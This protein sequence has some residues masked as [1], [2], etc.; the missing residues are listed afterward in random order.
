MNQRLK[1]LFAVVCLLAT[2]VVTIATSKNNS[3]ERVSNVQVTPESLVRKSYY[4]ASNCPQAIYQDWI[5]VANERIEYPSNRNF[6]SFGLPAQ[7]LNLTH[8]NQ[9]SMMINGRQRSCIRSEIRDQT[10]LPLIVYTCEESGTLLCQVSFEL[11]Q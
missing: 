2:S 7:T 4:V 11:D 1:S 9:I 8:T 5:T 3:G 6:S 10:G